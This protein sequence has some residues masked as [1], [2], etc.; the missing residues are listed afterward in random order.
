M[1]I[2]V[3]YATVRNSEL[4][5]EMQ[6]IAI[7]KNK[8][9]CLTLQNIITVSLFKIIMAKQKCIKIRVCFIIILLLGFHP[10]KINSQIEF[11]VIDKN[12]GIINQNGDIHQIEYTFINNTNKPIAI[13]HVATS[14]GCAMPSYDKKPV[15]PKETGKISVSFNPVGIKG[16]FNK[17]ITVY[18][19]GSPTPVKL[20]FKGNVSSNTTFKEGYNY[21][22]GNIQFRNIRT[23]LK[24]NSSN[25]VMRVI[26]MTNISDSDIEV[27][28]KTNVKGIF[29]DENEFL[30]KARSDKDLNIYYKPQEKNSIK[31]RLTDGCK[32]KNRVVL[33]VIEDQ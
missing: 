21:N 31:I 30:F 33:K 7:Q 8:R 22:I 24:S 6:M 19:S 15:M 17:Q 5:K 4:Q 26:P 10:T 28:I 16:F 29:F 1:Q 12:L 27:I 14:C 32:E 9:I 3:E 25:T 20:S 13:S 18:F 11:H 2:Y 23:T